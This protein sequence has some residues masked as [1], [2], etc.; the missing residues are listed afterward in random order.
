MSTLSANSRPRRHK[1]P[2]PSPQWSDAAI[3]RQQLRDARAE[4]DAILRSIPERD[5]I[6]AQRAV[7]AAAQSIADRTVA[8]LAEQGLLRQAPAKVGT[9]KT[10]VRDDQGRITGLIEQAAQIEP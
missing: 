3:L 8:A 6:V 9:V 10:I 2:A 4:R 1:R 5:R 7:D